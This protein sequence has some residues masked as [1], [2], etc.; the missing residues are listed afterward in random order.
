MDQML[1]V[2]CCNGSGFSN[3]ELTES[4][5]GGL[6]KFRGKFQEAEAVNKNKR[7]YPYDVLND[8]VKRLMESVKSRRLI[9]ELDHCDGG[10]N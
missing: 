7:I 1:F 9:G 10:I 8:N 3:M 6:V 4:I 5:S 2:D